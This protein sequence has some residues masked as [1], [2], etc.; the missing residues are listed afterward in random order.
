GPAETTRPAMLRPRLRR[1][2]TDAAS[3]S[4]AGHPGGRAN[5]ATRRSH[6]DLL[7]SSTAAAPLG[8]RRGPPV[9][10]GW[11]VSG[12]GAP[13]RCRPA[14]AAGDAPLGVRTP[15]AVSLR[16]HPAQT[17]DGASDSGI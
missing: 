2:G 16:G 6:R 12:S 9:A 4:S 11:S 5:P 17:V 8:A 3:R 13:D 15:D 7:L 1:C 14:V 10:G